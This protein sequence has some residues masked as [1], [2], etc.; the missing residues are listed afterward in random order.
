M[1]EIQYTGQAGQLDTTAVC[2]LGLADQE[3]NLTLLF[4]VRYSVLRLL[5]PGRIHR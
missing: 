2:L 1:Q 4:R 5:H 3:K